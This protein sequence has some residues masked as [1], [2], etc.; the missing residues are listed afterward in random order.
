MTGAVLRR[1]LKVA[2]PTALTARETLQRALGM[3]RAVEAVDR[4]ELFAL[5]WPG[6]VEAVAHVSRLAAKTNLL[7]NP[8]KHFLEVRSGEERITPRGNLWV[9]VW[10]RGEGSGIEETLRRRHLLDGEAPAVRRALLWELHLAGDAA[11]RK[12]RAETITWLRSREEG[13]LANPELQEA[14]VFAAGP[15]AEEIAGFLF[16]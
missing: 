2:D 8:N 13:L 3:G 5:R 6:P 9:M 15:S 10:R 16:S 1:W 4:S 11:E 14:H 7:V 12:S